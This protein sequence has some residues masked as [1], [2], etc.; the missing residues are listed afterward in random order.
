MERV[1]VLIDNIKQQMTEGEG[2]PD[3]VIRVTGTEWEILK[4]HLVAVLDYHHRKE[5]IK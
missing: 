1:S 4:D 5:A 2:S 3:K